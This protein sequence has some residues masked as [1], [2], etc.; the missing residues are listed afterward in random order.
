[1]TCGKLFLSFLPLQF[2]P[3]QPCR[4]LPTRAICNTS[5]NKQVDKICGNR[6]INARDHSSRVTNI[7]NVESNNMNGLEISCKNYS[8]ASQPLHFF[9]IIKPTPLI[10][11]EVST[12]ILT[13]LSRLLI[14]KTYQKVD[15]AQ[16]GKQCEKSLRI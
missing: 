7:S 5:S 11:M 4:S 9:G 8:G 15:D 6:R 13:D 2:S 1:M 16:N 3:L 14:M 10:C 12:D